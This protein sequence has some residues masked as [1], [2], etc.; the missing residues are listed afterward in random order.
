VTQLDEVVY[1]IIRER[2]AAGGD[3]GDVLS[4]LLQARDDDG[5]PMSDRQIRDETMTLA[6]AG[7][8]TTANALA[9]TFSRLSRHPEVRARMEEELDAL[10]SAR[11]AAVTM[12]E[13]KLLP[14][15]LAVLKES[16]RLHPPAFVLG[17][18]AERDVVVGDRLIRKGSL[19][20]INILGIHL[21]PD[22]WPEPSAFRPERFLGDAEK[23]LPRCSYMPFGAGPRVCIGS[24]FALLEAHLLLATIARRVRFDALAPEP[25]RPE[26]LV[27][28][29][30]QGGVRARAVVRS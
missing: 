9:W 6:L 20:L 12:E 8:E 23:Q 21:R 16:M 26:P 28:L 17:R 19:V 7:H 13:L 30:P 27:T 25:P 24:H 15:T 18:R 1:R 4:I 22:L 11:G 2:R 29:R 3:R 5:T 14:Y 10:P